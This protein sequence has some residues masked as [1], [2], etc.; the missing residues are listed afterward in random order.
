MKFYTMKMH[1]SYC[2]QHNNNIST[3]D[4]DKLLYNSVK[5][6][7][8]VNTYYK[9]LFERNLKRNSLQNNNNNFS[10]CIIFV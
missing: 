8:R 6:F 4:V 9:T 1:S 3:N 5:R 7:P 2:A 10:Y